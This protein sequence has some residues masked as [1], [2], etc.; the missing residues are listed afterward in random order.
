MT[1]Q[2]VQGQHW[3][4]DDDSSHS[5]RSAPQKTSNITEQLQS[6]CVARGMFVPP[7]QELRGTVPFD[8]TFVCACALF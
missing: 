2:Q 3:P 1:V 8:C 5:P 4:R 6:G 7:P